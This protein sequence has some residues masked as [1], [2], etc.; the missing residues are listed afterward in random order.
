[1]S[2]GTFAIVSIDLNTRQ[3]TLSDSS[4]WLFAPDDLQKVSQW[5]ATQLVM[6]GSETSPLSSYD[7]IL[8]NTQRQ[9]LA[10]AIQ[11]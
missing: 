4:V 11:Q 7:A 6:I 9:N 8:L 2:A 10:R 1:V 5:Q 3:I